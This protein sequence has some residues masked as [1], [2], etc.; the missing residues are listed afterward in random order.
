MKT[1]SFAYAALVTL[2]LGAPHAAADAGWVHS[3]PNVTLAK[4][5]APSDA[6]LFSWTMASRM[7]HILK[8]TQDRYG[9]RDRN[10]TLLGVEFT[11]RD[12]P[13][14]WYPNFGAGSNTIIIQLT[15]SAG[16]DEK[17]ALF[18]L[19]HEV[20][21]LLSPA[22]PN[23][24]ASVLEEGLAT[25]NSIEYLRNNGFQIQPD[26]ISAARYMRA[27]QLLLPLTSRPDFKSGIRALRASRQSLSRISAA[28]VMQVYPG[29]R[30][31]DAQALAAPF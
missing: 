21:H 6:C 19:A 5:C 17:Q 16:R 11:T 24:V 2:S 20:V 3:A 30:F 4:P 22:G 10:W 1:R 26:Y 15:E 27:Y 31:E 28:D 12:A 18:Q 25:Y 13:Q 14:V 7:G 29:L 9:K 8:F 23:G